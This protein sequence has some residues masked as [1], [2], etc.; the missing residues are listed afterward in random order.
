MNATINASPMYTKCNSKIWYT[1]SSSTARMNTFPTLSQPS[2]SRGAHPVGCET[3][4]QKYG[5]RPA[6]ASAS[7]ARIAK[8]VAI[9][10]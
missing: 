9:A 2:F 7:P 3:I 5:G 1:T 8:N 10:G 6:L 4:V